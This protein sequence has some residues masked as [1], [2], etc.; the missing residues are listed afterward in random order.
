MAKVVSER[1]VRPVAVWT[2]DPLLSCGTGQE[3]AKM[4]VSYEII[5]LHLTCPVAGKFYVYYCLST[6]F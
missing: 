3:E 2:V 6:M 1:I 5:D 4:G